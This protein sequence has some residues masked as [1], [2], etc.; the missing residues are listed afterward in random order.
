MCGLLACDQWSKDIATPSTFTATVTGGGTSS[1]VLTLNSAVTGTLWEGEVLGC[2]PYSTACSGMGGATPRITLGTQI[3][4][5]LSGSWGA[6]GSTYSLTSPAGP[7]GVVNV[8][9]Q[10]MLNEVYYS[11][12]APAVYAGGL[13][14]IVDQIGAAASLG[15]SEHPG[16]GW[17]EGGGL[18]LAP[19]SRRRRRSAPTRAWRRRRRFSAPVTRMRRRGARG[20]MLRRR[21]DL[22]RERDDDL[23][24]RLGADVQR[25]W[26]QCAADRRRHGSL[27]LGL[28]R[29]ALCRFGLNSPTQSI[30]AGAGQIGSANNGMTATLNAAPGVSG[31]AAFAFGL[32]GTSGTGSNCIDIDF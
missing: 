28:Q 31:A 20:A 3:T 19:A 12:G 2:N 7:T 14:D 30:V 21:L 5:I 27:L 11:G 32:P 10:P 25:P 24:Q 9:A 13:H 18:E 1:P 4:G 6:S 16:A 26:R 17:P 22:C 15:A 23:D 8:A 29:R